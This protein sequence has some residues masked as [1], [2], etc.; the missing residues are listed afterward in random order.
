MY[1]VTSLIMGGSAPDT[2]FFYVAQITRA[3]TSPGA[4]Y[5][6]EPPRTFPNSN[7]D[8]FTTADSGMQAIFIRNRAL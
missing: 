8:S 3:V 6:K 1:H 7:S 5:G 2:C 4:G